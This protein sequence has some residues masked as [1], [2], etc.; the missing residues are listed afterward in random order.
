MSFE[1]ICVLVTK[2]NYFIIIVKIS[3]NEHHNSLA[4]TSLFITINFHDNN[5]EFLLILFKKINKNRAPY[6]IILVGT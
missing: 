2:F 3:T 1:K 6:I 5:Q 4:S